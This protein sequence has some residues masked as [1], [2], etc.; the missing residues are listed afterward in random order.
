MSIDSFFCSGLFGLTGIVCYII[1]VGDAVIEKRKAETF[2]KLSKRH[3]PKPHGEI[4]RAVKTWAGQFRTLECDVEAE[5]GR[6]LPVDA[7]ITTWLIAL[8]ANSINLY[9][10]KPDGVTS[11]EAACG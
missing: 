4:E 11:H 5:T 1:A 3:D 8:A 6:H 10:T 2:P 9:K 7:A